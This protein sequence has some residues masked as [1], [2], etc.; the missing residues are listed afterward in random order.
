M[1]QHLKSHLDPS[2]IHITAKLTRV[3]YSKAKA[4]TACFGNI[5]TEEDEGDDRDIDFSQWE[6]Q[7]FD[8]SNDPATDVPL[9]L[10]TFACSYADGQ[11]S[12][13]RTG[14]CN[15]NIVIDD[16]A[17]YVAFTMDRK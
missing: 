10:S 15:G 7:V 2:S 3:R 17:L 11:D 16:S 14:V 12:N 9:G 4:F 8:C 1:Q 5:N 13:F 6:A